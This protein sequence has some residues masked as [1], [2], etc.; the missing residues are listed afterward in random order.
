M[1][2]ASIAILFSILIIF[3][4]FSEDPAPTAVA[5]LPFI[6]LDADNGQSLL[7]DAISESVLNNLATARDLV[8]IGRISSFQFRQDSSDL[9]EVRKALNVSHVV[10]GSIDRVEESLVEGDSVEGTGYRVNVRL[11]DTATGRILWTGVFDDPFSVFSEM[12][13]D[14]AADVASY[15]GIALSRAQGGETRPGPSVF[16]AFLQAGQLL[17]TRA[18]GAVREAIEI[19]ASVVETE[20]NFGAA[21]A[22]LARA[23]SIL[24]VLDQMPQSEFSLLRERA[25]R[26]ANVA[27]SINADDDRAYTV[28]GIVELVGEEYAAAEQSFV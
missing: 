6:D 3:E 5:V 15:W 25:K 18:L 7:A 14:I 11:I 1:L 17:D 20:P 21:H 16:D 19:L 8:V 10:E 27:I 13:Y 12:E 23:L 24:I 22:R 26:A 28:R 4:V 9:A 2:L